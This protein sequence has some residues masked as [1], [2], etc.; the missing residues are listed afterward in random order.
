MKTRLIKFVTVSL[1]TLVILSPEILVLGVVWQN[2]LGLEQIN[3]K[4]NFL[5]SSDNAYQASNPQ[6]DYLNNTWINQNNVESEKHEYLD[7]LDTF[8]IIFLL[9][10]LLFAF[11]SD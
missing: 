9:E 6:Y 4:T 5:I 11:L 7:L 10:L 1:V 2:H 8:K 3:E